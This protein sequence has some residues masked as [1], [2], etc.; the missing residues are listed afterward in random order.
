MIDAAA[1]ELSGRSGQ[2]GRADE[3]KT[4]GQDARV[5][6]VGAVWANGGGPDNRGRSVRAEREYHGVETYTIAEAARLCGIGP[7]ALRKRLDRGTIQSLKR[8]GVRRIPRSELERAG[9]RIGP[10]AEASDITREL[11]EKIDVQA[12]ELARLRALPER[13]ETYRLQAEAE[14]EARQA[15]EARAQA[16][17]EAYVQAEAARAAECEERERAAHERQVLEERLEC[18]AQA[19]WRERRRL[20]RELRGQAVAA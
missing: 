7:E 15:A 2:F 5:R 4:P 11:I 10:P 20:L 8:D 3:S 19:G 17:H 14:H 6:T 12:T 13:V 9:L 16:E 18:L 1:D